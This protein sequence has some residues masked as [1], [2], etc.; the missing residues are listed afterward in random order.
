MKINL[1]CGSDIKEGYNNIDARN[2]KN[3]DMV[4]DICLLDFESNSVEEIFA[5]DIIEHFPQNAIRPLLLRFHKWLKPGGKLIIRVP[6]MVTLAQSLVKE[7]RPK[8]CIQRIYGGQQY[9]GNFHKAGFT[10]NMMKDLLVKFS[11]VKFCD[12]DVQWNMEIEA[13][14]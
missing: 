9:A 12:D 11:S 5:S 10:K 3:V 6:N 14:K 4:K 8:E 1:G 13:I 2:L 7:D